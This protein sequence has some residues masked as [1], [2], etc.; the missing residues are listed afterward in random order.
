MLIVMDLSTILQVGFITF[1]FSFGVQAA[2]YYYYKFTNNSL[3]KKHK[4]VMQYTSGVIGDGILMP[5]TNIFAVLALNSQKIVI[6]PY[7]L[8]FSIIGGIITVFIFHYGQEYYNLKN[9]TMPD[10]GL[11]NLLGVYHAVFMFAESSFLCFVLINW[12]QKGFYSISSHAI[13]VGF[14]VMFVFF[15]TFV[16]DYWKPLF[17]NLLS[18]KS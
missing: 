1:V 8:L 16:Y 10:T 7:T 13:Y 4:A 18:K 5:L 12:V 17:R 11:W 9:W 14:L 15:I 2:F 3:I 6:E